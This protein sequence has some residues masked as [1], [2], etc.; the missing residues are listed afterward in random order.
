VK[1]SAL[2]DLRAL[3]SFA[4][5]DLS[6]RYPYFGQ[7]RAHSRPVAQHQICGEAFAFE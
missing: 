4:A 6:C 1:E 5:S 2:A 3:P 7:H